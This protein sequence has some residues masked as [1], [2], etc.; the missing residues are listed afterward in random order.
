MAAKHVNAA[1]ALRKLL[2]KTK[3]DFQAEI[4]S[5]LTANT[6]LPVVDRNIVEAELKNLLNADNTAPGAPGTGTCYYNGPGG[7][8]QCQANVTDATC[9]T[10]G[11]VF[12][13]G[14]TRC[15]LV[16]A[17]ALRAEDINLI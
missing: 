3:Q 16:V 8:L 11:G 17:D 14:E 10:L 7:T 15:M 9:T 13:S 1:K 5:I 6:V 4:V 12:V 2:K